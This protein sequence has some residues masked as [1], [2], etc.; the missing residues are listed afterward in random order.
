M[1]SLT[2][3]KEALDYHSQGRP[4]KIEVVAT[5]P[6]LTQIDLSLAYTPGV[7]EPCREIAKDPSKVYDYTAKGNLVAVV[8][9]GSA[10][11]GLGN[12]G[13]DAGK[14]VMEGK[15][16][17]FKRFADIDVFD[18]ELGTQDV[19]EIIA[20]VTA[21]APTF[22]G[23][24][25]EDISSPR[26]FE[27]EKRLAETL[28][29]PVF[30][31][32]Q[33]GTAL[34]TGAALINALEIANKK[35]AE[36]KIVVNGAGAAA[37]ACANYAV[38]LGVE[39]AN[40]TMCDSIGVIYKGRTERMNKYKEPFAVDT[41]A[42]TLADAM[43]C[44]DVFIGVSVGNVVTPDMLRSMAA[45]P[46]VLAMSN[47][48]PEIPYAD[49]VAARSDVIM[50]TGR[51][52]HPN[53]VNNVLGFPFLFR[54]ALD[55][56]A[57]C[58]N[59]EM[60]HAATSALADLAK[61]P[62]PLSVSR[63][64]DVDKLEFGPDYLIPKPL[65][66]RV[67]PRVC[68]AVARAAI[69]SGVARKEID[70]DSYERQVMERL[71]PGRNF[72]SRVVTRARRNPV[73]I[74]YPEG[75]H[76][77]TLRAAQAVAREKIA[78]PILVGPPKEIRRVAEER[79]LSLE[80]LEIVDP[81][82]D[83]RLPGMAEELR[84]IRAHRKQL[85]LEEAKARLQDATWFSSM[86]LRAGDAEGLVCGVTRHVRKS[87]QPILKVIPLRPGYRL[88]C[89][90]SFTATKQGPLFLTD[91]AVNIDPSAEDLSDIALLAAESVR[92]FDVEPVVA[93]LSFSSFGGSPHPRSDMVRRAVELTRAEDPNLIIDGE[94]RVDA[95]L[96]PLLQE[97]YPDCRLGGRRA[98]LLVFPDLGA[99]N[100]SYNLL[101]MVSDSETI[102]PMILGL[103][104]AVS[105]LQPHSTEVEDI[106]RLT[107]LACVQA[108]ERSLAH[109]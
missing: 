11:L 20:A 29:I 76:E 107:A 10:V 48:D 64:Y 39:R 46:I 41:E 21:I 26:C 14:P 81:A 42:R 35:R 13:P 74:L 1:S 18:I 55:V 50:A 78:Q 56:R 24:N 30:H 3:A 17:L 53:Q 52:D 87:I 106:I 49:A 62:V 54:G 98:N 100:I 23:I 95:A 84:K 101:R 7:A 5:K 4:G 6:C 88:A 108:Q 63:A 37:I 99:A 69:E 75:A 94:M 61:E 103:D 43:V 19:E 72:M 79:G 83:H 73:R 2:T 65:D 22:S 16:V 51:S 12:I 45:T 59:T 92:L 9:D 47:P 27:I 32:D 40:I 86:M 105:V 31:D 66:S 102:G 68:S 90:L 15:A 36:A 91:T 38:S 93:M 57:R 104:R 89:G 8:T 80:G 33:H 77:R 70:L 82:T 71:G 109:A 28:D 58:I 34:I 67:L 97:R 96:D 60:M 85:S 44:S 25:L